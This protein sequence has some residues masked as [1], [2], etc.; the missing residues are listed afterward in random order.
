MIGELVEGLLQENSS[1]VIQGKDCLILPIEHL[2]I[3]MLT[4]DWKDIFPVKINRVSKH[5]APTHYIKIQIGNGRS[6]IV[7]PEHPFFSIKDGKIITKRAD[8]VAVGDWA[9]VPLSAPIEGERQFFGINAKKLHNSRAIRHILVPE[10]NCEEFFKIVGYLAAE[11]SKERNRGKLIG[12]NF[13][14][15]DPILLGDFSSCMKELF[16]LDPYEQERK[17]HHDAR[18]MLRYVSTEL[19]EFFRKTCPGLL[20]LADKKELPQVVMRGEKRN[21]AAMLRCLFEGDGLI[22]MRAV[23]GGLRLK[24]REI[25]QPGAGSAAAL[26]HPEQSNPP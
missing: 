26:C 8:E 25:G 20:E 3:E 10:G 7:T 15:K 21:I 9:P 17:D 23:Q 14:N 24:Q 11:G 18:W 13:T 2:G 12:I 4:T 1:Q 16:G 6:V 19:A 22:K 5:I